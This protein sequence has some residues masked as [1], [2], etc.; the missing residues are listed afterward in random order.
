M[1]AAYILALRHRSRMNATVIDRRYK[2]K[3]KD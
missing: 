3:R 2:E 1:T